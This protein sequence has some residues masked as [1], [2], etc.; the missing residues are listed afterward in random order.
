MIAA[1][2]P[3]APGAYTGTVTIWLL[4]SN[5]GQITSTTIFVTVNV[6][7]TCSI[8]APA[9]DFGVYSGSAATATTTLSVKCANGTAYNVGLNGGQSGNVNNRQLTFGS[10]ALNYALYSNSSR[11]VNWGDTGGSGTAGG[12][13]NSSAQTLTVYGLIPGGQN[14]P[15]GLYTDTITATLTY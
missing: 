12:T 14:P 13:G 11:T 3:P 9:M 7:N 6:G 5:K 1:G 2:T 10:S 8:S 15:Q 4:D